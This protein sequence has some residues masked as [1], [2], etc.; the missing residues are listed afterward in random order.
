MVFQAG[1]PREEEWE[2]QEDCG[3]ILPQQAWIGRVALYEERTHGI[4]KGILGNVYKSTLDCVDGYHGIPLAE[5][6][7]HKTTFANEWG[8]SGT[9]EHL[10]VTYHQGTATVNTQMPY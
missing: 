4:A 7:R 5:D 1:D 9:P 8:N 3:P 2:G 6:D 10:R